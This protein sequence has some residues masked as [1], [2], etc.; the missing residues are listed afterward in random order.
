MA[1]L[2][3]LDDL[4]GDTSHLSCTKSF[5]EI[6]GL[7]IATWTYIE[8]SKTHLQKPPVIAIHGGPAFT[9][10]YILPLKLLANEGYPIVFYDQAGCGGSTF[11]ENPAE[12][13]PWLLTINYYVEEVISLANHFDFQSY[14]LFGSSW[15][16]VV[17]QETAVTQ[18]SGLLGLILDGALSDGQLYIS[19]QWRDRISKL[20]S[21]TQRLLRKL[22]DEKNFECP[23]MKVLNDT[24]THHFTT[25]LVPQP[26]CFLNCFQTG[27]MNQTIYIAMQG[28]C[29][30]TIGGVLE[31]WSITDRLHT[32]TVPTLVMVGEFDTMTDECCQT[33]V[34]HIPTA[35][36]LVKIPRAAHCK[37]IDE[38]QL[39]VSEIA[40]FLNTVESIRLR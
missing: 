39:C 23:A 24:I 35:W 9:H 6:R 40:K 37:L 8:V 21:F 10:N 18:P 16:T 3:T 32:V 34:D 13:A 27:Q 29:E 11:V 4:I 25:R 33:I 14:Y 7:T 17:C 15:G 31:H 2:V 1:A 12:T 19:T 20:P 36:P 38:P 26:D 30:F 5:F 22:I 28:E